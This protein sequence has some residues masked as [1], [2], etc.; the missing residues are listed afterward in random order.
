MTM[1]G[2]SYNQYD[3]ADKLRLVQSEEERRAVR[4]KSPPIRHTE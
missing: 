2:I 4:R 3:D 1:Q